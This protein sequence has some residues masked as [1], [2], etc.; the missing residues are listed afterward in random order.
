MDFQCI[1]KVSILILLALPKRFHNSSSIC[2][3]Q[4]N[5]GNISRLSA[6]TKIYILNLSIS[7]LNLESGTRNADL[8]RGLWS[9]NLNLAFRSN[10]RSSNACIV[11]GL[12]DRDPMVIN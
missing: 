6:I 8:P 4:R 7:I 3:W 9:C 10:D 12:T 5:A 2:A 1:L 11:H